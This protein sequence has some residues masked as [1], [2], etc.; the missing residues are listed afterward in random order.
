MKL[1]KLKHWYHATTHERAEQ[2]LRDGCI[3]NMWDAIYMAN[4]RQY[5]GGFM[6][7][8]GLNEWVVFKIPTH[9][10]NR[11]YLNLSNDHAP[12]FFPRDLVCV[13]YRA[14]SIPVSPEDAYCM[15]AAE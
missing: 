5:A 10:L 13:Q 1:P 4:S 2:I 7:M 15:E 14:D 6:R 12:Q 11:Q 3:K 8:K 9:R